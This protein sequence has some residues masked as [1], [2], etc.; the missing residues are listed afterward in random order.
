M[1]LSAPGFE[2]ASTPEPL[3]FVLAG[4][5]LVAAMF[6]LGNHQGRSF[7]PSVI[8]LLLGVAVAAVVEAIDV[9]WLDPIRDAVL[10]EHAAELA[11]IVALFT[12]GLAVE[13][14]LGWR[15]WGSA[16]RLIG[17]VMPLTIVAVAVWGNTIMGLTVAGAIV[18]GAVLAPTDPV[19]AGDL[20]VG[21]PGE[22]D[23]SEP[24]FAVTSEA[25]LNDGLAFP[26]V[27]LGLLIAA[28]G[29]WA[30]AWVLGDVIW[31]IGL[32]LAVGAAGGISLG[33]LYRRW[34]AAGHVD[35]SADA[36]IALAAVLAV[37]GFTEALDA[38]GFLAAF[39]AGLGFSHSEASHET[40]RRVHRGAVSAEKFGE[41]VLVLLVGTMLSSKGV[42]LPG[43]EGWALVALL[44][45]V[46]R[47][48]VTLLAFLGS[49]LGLRERLFIG[50]FG[51]RGVGSIY[52]AAFAAASAQLPQDEAR[53]IFW[54][55]LI[56]ATT[57]ILVHGLSAEPL[58]KAWLA[59]DAVT[60]GDPDA[61]ARERQ[62]MEG[63]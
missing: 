51:V 49:D 19:L 8:Y 56:A 30:A 40:D 42:A 25:G 46:I 28:G 15:R 6:A 45:L 23:D 53:V 41:L 5:A 17:I 26:F 60:P 13:R 54:T 52:Y 22:P 43:W 35:S 9:R 18:L 31:G 27:M 36:W 29:D 12:T 62:A 3:L 38:Y 47:P 57:S 37:Y 14:S 21:P 48:L 55:A 2:P 4:V 61:D 20:G 1:L 44:L 32:A 11:V 34:R 10:I 50:W 33:W 16:W 58:R 63:G 59:E 24:R 7:S 39:A